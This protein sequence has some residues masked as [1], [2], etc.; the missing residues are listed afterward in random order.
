LFWKISKKALEFLSELTERV[1][2][3]GTASN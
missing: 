3:F 2:L 1:D